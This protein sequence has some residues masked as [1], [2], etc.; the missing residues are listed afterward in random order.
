MCIVAWNIYLHK[1][2][3]VEKKL[4]FNLSA[5]IFDLFTKLNI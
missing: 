2:A 1:I 3:E 5:E 4:S